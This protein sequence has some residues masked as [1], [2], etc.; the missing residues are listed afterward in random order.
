MSRTR[1]TGGIA[2]GRARPIQRGT[3][4]VRDQCELRLCAT[5]SATR[6]GQMTG[7]S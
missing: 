2:P 4:T 7:E 1:S 3:A 6:S 5:C